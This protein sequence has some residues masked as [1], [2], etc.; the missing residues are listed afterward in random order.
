MKPYKITRL[1]Q[2]VFL[3]EDNI[4]LGWLRKDREGWWWRAARGDDTC[5][6]PYCTRADAAEA[7]WMMTTDAHGK[8]LYKR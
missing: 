5:V 8:A 2:G 1:S 4:W 3:R 6:E 7:L